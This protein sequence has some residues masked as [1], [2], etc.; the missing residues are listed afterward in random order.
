[1][2]LTLQLITVSVIILIRELTHLEST[3]RNKW[4]NRYDYIIVG[5]GSAGTVVA[6]RL[7]EDYNVNVLLIEAGGPQSVVTDIPLLWNESVGNTLVDYNYYEVPQTHSSQSLVNHSSLISRGRSLGGTS[8][9]NAMIY[10]RGNRRDFD[11]WSRIYGAK[12]FN[13]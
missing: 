13:E 8:V 7:T 10:N 5:A 11:Q 1:M 12:G 3:S 2:S 4:R 6:V 9:L